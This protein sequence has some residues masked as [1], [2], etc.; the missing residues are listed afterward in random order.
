M[1]EETMSSGY[2]Q[3]HTDPI[4]VL[5]D[6]SETSPAGTGR[7]PV[8]GPAVP[9]SAAAPGEVPP[10]AEP[11]EQHGTA[12]EPPGS[13]GA[14]PAD[15]DP[16]PFHRTESEF[17]ESRTDRADHDP[18]PVSEPGVGAP[19]ASGSDLTDE[20]TGAVLFGDDVVE[21]FRLRWREVQADFVDDPARAVQ[22]ADGLVDEV[23]RA[24]TEVFAAHKRDLEDQWRGGGTG[25]TEEL[26][27]ALR[28]YRSFFD[29]LLNT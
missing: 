25:E 10:R 23:L 26:R 27:V 20:D 28:S 9:G 8:P 7:A 5:G 15:P 12:T 24:L 17:H 1:R 22:G 11:A 4:P 16:T 18:A 19:A 14:P 3:P 6:E 13:V 29:R 21:R 2:D